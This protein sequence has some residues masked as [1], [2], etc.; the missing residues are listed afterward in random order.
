MSDCGP[1]AFYLAC[2]RLGEPCTLDQAFS[3]CP[4]RLNH[5]NSFLDLFQAFLDKGLK[6]Q[7]LEIGLEQLKQLAVDPAV[8]VVLHMP[9]HF[10]LLKGLDSEGRFELADKNGVVA[11][12]E[13]QLGVAWDGY[14]L[15]VLRSAEGAAEARQ[16]AGGPAYWEGLAGELRA[17]GCQVELTTATL[18]QLKELSAEP[19]VSLILS[20]SRHYPLLNAPGETPAAD[21]G[22][23]RN[24]DHRTA[25]R[26]QGGQRVGCSPCS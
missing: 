19:G 20:L 12:P 26:L 10:Q 7:A 3:A 11:M 2:Q 5:S 13:S 17:K 24:D 15:V 22:E 8:A 23:H 18:S 1:Y 25:R 4:M 9:N 16:F 21:R 6:V 14:V